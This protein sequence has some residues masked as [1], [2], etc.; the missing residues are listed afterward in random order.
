MR[1]RPPHVA[2]V[3]LRGRRRARHHAR[4]EAHRDRARLPTT[5]RHVAAAAGVHPATASRALNPDTRMLVN[6]ET[7]Q[8]VLDA[9][10]ELGYRPNAI[11][12]GL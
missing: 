6:A 10:A 1:K 5:L 4:V 12:R 3:A 9:A 7:A 8:R 2:G 11:A